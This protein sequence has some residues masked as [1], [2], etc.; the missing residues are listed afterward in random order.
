[1]KTELPLEIRLRVMQTKPGKGG[2][3]GY[4]PDFRE[5][6]TG[7]VAF[8]PGIK[9]GGVIPVMNVRDIAPAISK[10]LGSSFASAEGKIPADLLTKD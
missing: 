8:G 7:F 4:F 3:H 9:K 6:Q 10:L 1:V 2:A 5:I